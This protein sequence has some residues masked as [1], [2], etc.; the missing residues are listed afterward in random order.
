MKQHLDLL[1][2][3]SE[4]VFLRMNSVFD[5]SHHGKWVENKAHS[6][7]DVWIIQSGTV[8]IT[9]NEREHIAKP[10][11]IVFFYPNIPYTATS[12]SERCHFVFVHFD[13]GMG[14]QPRILGDF[15]LSGIIPK[16]LIQKEAEAFTSVYYQENDNRLYLKA[17]FTALIAKIIEV[18]QQGAYSGQFLVNNE[19]PKSE[20]SL[21]MLQPVFRYINHNLHKPLKMSELALISGFSEKYF[22]TYFKRALGISPGQYIYYIRMNRARGYLHTNK[23]TIQQIAE[24]LGYPDPFT[25]SKAF[26]KYYKVAPSKFAKQT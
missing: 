18:Y 10:G 5:P 8:Q 2:E 6:D 23:Y 17:F 22:I 26:K 1:G 21:D 4:S 9:I 11:D 16:H 13:F 25:F 14:S 20:L 15:Q 12:I 19:T 3:L 7:Y 24:K